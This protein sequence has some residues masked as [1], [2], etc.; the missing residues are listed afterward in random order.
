MDSTAGKRRKLELKAKFD[1]CL[2]APGAFNTSFKPF[3]PAP[4]DH[5]ETPRG[6]VP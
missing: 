5:E 2:S 4:A 1:S 6:A 3:Q